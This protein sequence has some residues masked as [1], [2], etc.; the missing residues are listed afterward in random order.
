MIKLSDYIKKSFNEI[1][2][3]NYTELETSFLYIIEKYLE[4]QGKTLEKF[5][6]ENYILN[7]GRV[8]II[9]LDAVIPEGIDELEGP[10]V[11]E[12]R[13]NFSDRTLI[14]LEKILTLNP[15]YKSILIVF[16]NALSIK[17]KKYIENFILANNFDI[18]VKLWDLNDIYKLIEKLNIDTYS[19]IDNINKD[20]L[21]NTVK[22]AESSSDWR[23]DSNI[24]INDL[25]QSFKNDEVFFFLGAGV[26]KDAGVPTW[27]ELLRDLNISII[28]SKLDF[29][30]E[31]SQKEEILSLLTNIQSG[32]PVIS[33][34]YIRTALNEEFIS[35]IRKNIY[36]NVKSIPQQK[37]IKSIAKAS[38]PL[39]G[40]HGL[41]GIITYNFDDLLEQ[42]FENLDIDYKSI[43]REGDFE[44]PTKR[45][46]YHVHGFIPKTDEN[47]TNLD[48]SLLVFSEDGYHILQNDPYSWSNLV[49]LK[50]LR[51]HTCVL[52]GLSGI[53]PNLRRLFSNFSKRYDGCK[54][55][56]LLQRQLT[57]KKSVLS[58][59]EFQ[60]FSNLHHSLQENVFKEIGLKVIWYE[61]H[62]ELPELI[63]KISKI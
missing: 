58:N 62:S 40:K 41:R 29:K 7:D 38:R 24:L 51:E 11:L 42:Q 46:I 50:A 20:I 30:L 43:Y 48:K 17:D 21:E 49:Q 44:I 33:A 31:N 52:I 5:K 37:L 15:N 61:E 47:Y 34:S 19:I 27:D 60:K 45:P 57:N 54:H 25:N 8:G 39:I 59:T 14:Y 26:S 22:K 1:Y 56:I 55:Y 18:K 4:S 9:E 23:K 35:E 28:E 10:T 3:L 12:I 6:K 2:K 36:K 63:N 53:D 16:G 32:A 13:R